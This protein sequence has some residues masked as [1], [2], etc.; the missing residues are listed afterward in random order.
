M[1]V[2]VVDNHLKPE[3]LTKY[4][5]GNIFIETGTYLGDTVTLALAHGYKEIHSIELNQQLY[6]NATKQFENNSEVYLWLGDSVVR[7]GE[8]VEDL[9]DAGPAT[10]WLDAHASGGLSG[11]ISGGS[12]V[13]DELRIIQKSGRIDNTIF[14]DDK[15]LFGSAEWSYVKEADALKLLEEINPRYHI[16]YLDGHE[17]GDVICATVKG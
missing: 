1:L 15:R 7:L 9:K 8:I 5:N 11:G 3:Y 10:F 17:P 6:E 16:F 13:L 12:P 4:G 2:R 14:I